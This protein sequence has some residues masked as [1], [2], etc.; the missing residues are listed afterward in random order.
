MF[1]EKVK[2]VFLEIEADPICMVDP[3][4]LFINVKFSDEEIKMVINSVIEKW[5]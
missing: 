5:A 1:Q 4:I 3:D 2:I